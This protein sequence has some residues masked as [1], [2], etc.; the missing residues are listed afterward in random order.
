MSRDIHASGGEFTCRDTNIVGRKSTLYL[1]NILII[2][3]LRRNIF[4]KF[5]IAKFCV[6]S[7]F[8]I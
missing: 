4:G 5:R 1:V 2:I 8:K 6:R 7:D 3:E